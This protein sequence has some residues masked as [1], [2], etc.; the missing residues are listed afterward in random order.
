MPHN[1]PQIV[2]CTCGC[3]AAL[4]MHRRISGP[5]SCQVECAYSHRGPEVLGHSAASVVAAIAG[6][7]ALQE[8]IT[9]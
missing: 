8:G 1:L 6:W 3:A 2:N 4:F 7:V 5:E 9:L